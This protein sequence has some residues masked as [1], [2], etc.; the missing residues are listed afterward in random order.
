MKIVHLAKMT[1]VSGMEKHLLSLLPG[2]RAHGID[3]SLLVLTERNRPMDT[4]LASMRQLGVPAESIMIGADIDPG[5]IGRLTHRFRESRYDAV[6]THL[7]HADLYG[8]LA[9]KRAGIR[10]IFMTGHNDDR[11][12]R[13]WP[14]R[15]LQGWLWRQVAGG[16]AISRALRDFVI[17][18]EFAP[19]ERVH[20]VHY[21]YDPRPDPNESQARDAL[22]RELNLTPQ[23][24]IV[25]SMCRLIEQKGLTHAIRAFWQIAEQVQGAHYIIVGD[26]P[27]R[28][29]LEQQVEGFQLKKRVHFLGWRDDAAAL[30]PAFDALLMPSLWEGFGIVAL[31]A[32][33]AR[34]PVIASRVSALPE[35]VENGVTGFLTEPANA[36]A[37][38]ECLLD[39]LNNPA[40]AREMGEN[41]RRRLEAEFG[42]QRMVDGTLKVYQSA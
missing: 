10:R 4:Y 21:G 5:L 25:G 18:Y 17:R 27:L 12:R 39:V 24:P 1:G 19:P 31:E 3:A 9:A 30:L 41:G 28:A 29:M 7:I 6:H 40:L 37:L 2:L 23:A 13:R 35:I 42:V 8:I 15:L 36:S 11:F 38:A 20:V 22:C 33:A 14:V 16:I 34:V 32:M 26:G